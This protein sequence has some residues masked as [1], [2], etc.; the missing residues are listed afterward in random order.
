MSVDADIYI[1]A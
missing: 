1:Q